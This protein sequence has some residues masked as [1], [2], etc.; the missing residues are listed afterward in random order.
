MQPPPPHDQSQL[1]ADVRAAY[2][3]GPGA[4]MALVL[5]LLAER[6]A[7]LADL[8]NRLA[9][10]EARLAKDSHNSSAPP[11]RDPV[12]VPKSLRRRSGR[13]P[14]GTPGHEG[15][16]LEFTATPAVVHSYVPAR[17]DG[18]GA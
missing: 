12:R 3:I 1:A 18:C 15:T 7:A 17:C 10:L 16:T 4:V 2:A 6:D 11:S 13:P 8:R 9:T 14:G 5:A